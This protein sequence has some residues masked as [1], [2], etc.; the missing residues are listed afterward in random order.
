MDVRLPWS[1]PSVILD[2]D[3]VGSCE[4]IH[5]S[6]ARQDPMSQY[7]QIVVPRSWENLQSALKHCPVDKKNRQTTPFLGV[8]GRDF[9]GDGD[10][11]FPIIVACSD[12]A[13]K[14]FV[15]QESCI[16]CSISIAKVALRS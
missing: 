8:M 9:S 15:L 6:P 13:F 5:V 2:T 14:R 3:I 16:C 1:E 11:D 7:L 10:M 12:G 4:K